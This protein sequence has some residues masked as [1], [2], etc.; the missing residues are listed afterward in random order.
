M[1]RRRILNILCTALIAAAAASAGAVWWICPKS[2]PGKIT[3]VDFEYIRLIEQ[4]ENTEPPVKEAK[5]GN[6]ERTH[7]IQLMTREDRDL[8]MRVAT[9]EGEDQGEDGMWLI[10]SVIMNRVE[11]PEWP[12]NVHDVIYQCVT[13][14]AGVKHYQFSTI[15]DGRAETAEPTEAC[16]MAMVRIEEGEIAPEIIAFDLKDAGIL[17]KY[18]EPVFDYRDH[19]F[20]V[21]K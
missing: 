13:D 6:I 12:D 3:T 2:E 9:A 15:M 14:K 1:R 5:I 8:M 16:E 21:K 19:R 11:D 7:D 18:F 17:E 10:L 20:F 4:R